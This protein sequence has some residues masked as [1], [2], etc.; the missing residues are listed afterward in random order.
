MTAFALAGWCGCFG[1]SGSRAGSLRF[2]RKLGERKRPEAAGVAAQ[3]RTAVECE[4]GLRRHGEPHSTYRKALLA[5]SI[6]HRSA[7]A[8]LSASFSFA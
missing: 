3:E 7:Q 6:W 5:K 4:V 1:A 2:G 8:R